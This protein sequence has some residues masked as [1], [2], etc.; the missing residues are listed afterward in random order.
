MFLSRLIGLVSN[1]LDKVLILI[2]LNIS[3]VAVYEVVNKPSILIRVVVSMVYS[4]IIPEVARLN[5]QEE[6]DK[7]K[8][9]M[10]CLIRYAYL[11]V[12]PI[13]T[14][15]FVHVS[16]LLYLWVGNQFT[17]YHKLVTILIISA[18]ITPFSS[19]VSTML[20]GLEMVKES[21]WIPLL[22][23]AI[24]VIFS[25]VFVLHYGLTGLILSTLA[26]QVVVLFCYYYF[27]KPIFNIHVTDIVLPIFYL[28]LISIVFYF[29]HYLLPGISQQG[30]LNWV[31]TVLLIVSC[32]YL[33]G[34]IFFLKPYEK[35]FL[36]KKLS[37][38]FI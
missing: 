18:T 8:V 32:Q 27:V 26:S 3:K 13:T 24:N 9:L 22:G 23:T 35:K 11:I 7:I 37:S 16:E 12:F 28:V 25:L 38:K 19:I 2:F 4:A 15:I 6:K 34:F 5:T 30:V 21:I 1:N 10:V 33:I 31:V 29:I 36:L 14:M 17:H 20:V